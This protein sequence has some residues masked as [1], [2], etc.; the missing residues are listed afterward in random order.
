MTPDD[1][2]IEMARFD[3]VHAKRLWDGSAATDDAPAWYGRVATLLRASAAP[4]TEDELAGESDIVARMQAAILEPDI[5]DELA[6][7]SDIVA[8]MQA[9]ILELAPE[10]DD[11]RPRHLRAAAPGA[12]G[13]R[14]HQGARVVRRI[15]AVKAAAITTVVAI[16]VTAAAATTGIVATV[17]MPALSGNEQKVH[18]KPNAPSTEDNGSSTDGS[19]DADHGGGGDGPVVT[20]NP[21]EPLVCMLDLGCLINEVREAAGLPPV[22]AATGTLAP[23]SG[24]PTDTSVIDPSV[25]SEPPPAETPPVTSSEIPAEPTPS[26]TT[27]TEPPTTTPTEAPS[28]TTTTAPPADPPPPEG[29]VAL[30]PPPAASP[31]GALAGDTGSATGTSDATVDSGTGGSEPQPAS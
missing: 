22:S 11:D 6:G 7:E 24:A 27:T 19:R 13:A 10:T 5:E 21:E 23:D 9:T 15:V 18:I 17:V 4:A 14:R 8:R 16:G 28:T 29:E 12:A 1:R 20:M 3:P 2:W 30:P 31:L 26:T 25:V